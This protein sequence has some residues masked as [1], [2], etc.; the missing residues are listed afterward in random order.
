V[1]IARLT[2]RHA[3]RLAV[4]ITGVSFTVIASVLGLTFLVLSWQTQSRLRRAVA[5]DLE[6]SQ[7][8][9]A[10]IE[11]RRTRERRLQAVALAEN[12]TLKAAVDTYV[13]EL[14]QG[15]PSA[16]LL[17]TIRHEVVKLADL[18]GVPALA[19]VD[20]TGAI[21]ASAGRRSN[22]WPPGASVAWAQAEGDEVVI[23]R[24]RGL[25]LATTVPLQLGLDTVGTVLLATPLD[26]AY[27]TTLSAGARADVVIFHQG[28]VVAR[29]T[30]G[31]LR[32][33]IELAGLPAAGPVIVNGQE[34]VVRRLS[35]L[36]S[37]DV[38]AVSSVASAATATTSEVTRV[39][40]FVGALALLLAGAAS[41]WLA[42]TL[43]KPI[44]E[45]TVSL[46]RMA[47]T[48]DLDEPLPRSGVSREIDALADSFDT[49]R[50]AVSQAEAE[51][52]AAYLGV[53]GALAAALDARD[54]YTAG[55]SQRVAELSVLLA[56]EMQLSEEDR[57]TLRLGALLHD[58]GKIGI[59][60]S[61]LRKPGKLTQEEFDH[62]KLHPVLGA[63]ILRPLA[64][65]APHLPVVELHHERLDGRGYPLGLRGDDIPLFARI[66][67]VADAFDAMTSARA[68]RPARPAA[69]AMAELWRNVGTD[70]DPK[71]V[72]AMAAVWD[73]KLIQSGGESPLVAAPFRN[74]VNA[75]L[76]FRLR[77]RLPQ[78]AG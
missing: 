62:I 57:E 22:D 67:H 64:F 78:T 49:L 27:A 9:F 29:S 42:R 37:T 76:P 2:S 11:A 58:V 28:Q 6:G 15:T 44:D 24:G 12:P 45:L 52:D 4:W 51:S 18:M 56:W 31:G 66:V 50:S 55:H 77:P 14:K 47:E 34:L 10:D 23:S 71:V 60:D 40:F 1:L 41:L 17:P 19:L 75:A 3:P 13:S 30:A 25:F 20:G 53:I 43:A 46:A 32:K 8:R 63:R 21:L 74:P 54:P 73:T 69:E 61:V 7:Q 16:D 33:E 5:D 72:Q 59:S 39:M 48:K 36:G 70:F 26:D 38:Y 35:Q 68:Y 65:L